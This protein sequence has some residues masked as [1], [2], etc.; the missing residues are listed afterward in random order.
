[1][2]AGQEAIVAALLRLRN[3][4][5]SRV[6]EAAAFLQTTSGL[7]DGSLA[8]RAFDTLNTIWQQA[9]PHDV[10]TIGDSVFLAYCTLGGGVD[11][12]F[13]QQA[14]QAASRVR[15]NE[16]ALRLRR[17]SQQ[18]D[19][20]KRH[21]SQR[22]LQNLLPLV[23]NEAYSSRARIAA[24]STIATALI[25]D[26]SFATGKLCSSIPG[27]MRSLCQALA[28][29][30][31]IGNFPLPLLIG[32]D[33]SSDLAGL[34]GMTPTQSSGSS[35]ADPARSADRFESE[36]AVRLLA[37]WAISEILK[38]SAAFCMLTGPTLE[39][40]GALATHPGALPALLKLMASHTSPCVHGAV[41]AF[42]MTVTPIMGAIQGLQTR[43]GN[44]EIKALIPA[45]I[46]GAS[47]VMGEL[48]A[49]ED[50]PRQVRY[51]AI[52][53]IVLLAQHAPSGTV[54]KSLGG[55]G[56]LGRHVLEAIC[57]EDDLQLS[58]VV[59]IVH[60]LIAKGELRLGQ[61]DAASLW[62]VLPPLLANE[63]QQSTIL[64]TMYCLHSGIRQGGD[65]GKVPGAVQAVTALLARTANYAM[66]DARQVEYVTLAAEF[67]TM[68]A[69]GHAA[70]MV[71]GGAP[72]ALQ[73]LQT[74]ARSLFGEDWQK[75]G[76]EA[77]K[78]LR[79]LQPAVAAQ[80]REQQTREAS[81]S[82]SAQAAKQEG[83]AAAAGAGVG[84]AGVGGGKG[85]GEKAK[86]CS[87]CGKGKADGVKLRRCNGC[88]PEGA[89]IYC[90]SECENLLE[91]KGHVLGYA[92]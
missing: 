62:A 7:L 17:H 20:Y 86:V 64:N 24:L 72:A 25:Y 23:S 55:A 8:T 22:V 37:V 61:A 35:G 29:P 88:A 42:G 34:L 92:G 80:Q 46:S 69:R 76:E 28:R 63:R 54:L 13:A 30:P 48:P 15:P 41:L 59:S 45:A 19:L 49:A 12:A 53:S 79:A 73:K 81:G 75:A 50:Y 85:A 57:P 58:S 6:D 4:D 14:P 11:P 38:S 16:M 47:R 52:T 66:L 84:A 44:R 33:V 91:R 21:V 90:S 43:L 40:F 65:V 60:V 39:P 89:P 51:Y 74:K 56:S 70:E 27:A 1:M 5:S 36:E 18:S 82:S 10:S 67:V 9:P 31:R 32:R 26:T 3:S 77:G 71:R 83:P 2:A 68:A 78:A 87:V